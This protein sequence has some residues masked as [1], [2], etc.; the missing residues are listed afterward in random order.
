MVATCVRCGCEFKQLSKGRLFLLPPLRESADFM[1]R[2]GRL[3]DYC[4]WLCSHCS[5]EYVIERE[6]TE[7]IVTKRNQFQAEKLQSHEQ[8]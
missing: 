3:A 8:S 4:Y 5:E 7:L 2:V 1:W 6:G